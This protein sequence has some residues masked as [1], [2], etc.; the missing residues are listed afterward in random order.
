VKALKEW[1]DMQEMVD[2]G[3]LKRSTLEKALVKV[4][5]YES[6]EITLPQ[7]SQLMDIIQSAVDDASLSYEEEDEEDEVEQRGAKGF[8]ASKKVLS[9]EGAEGEEQEEGGWDGDE[10]GAPLEISEEEAAQEIF[11]ELKKPGQ[12]TL[13]LVDFLKW[14]DVQELVESGAL[15]RDNLAAAIENAGVSVEKGDMN[16]ETVSNYDLP[17]MSGV[18]F[19]V[20]AELLKSPRMF[21]IFLSFL[22]VYIFALFSQFYDLLQVIDNYVDRSKIPID[23]EGGDD[24]VFEKRITVDEDT[25]VNKVMSLVDGLLEDADPVLDDEE[26]ELAR[27]GSGSGNGSGVKGQGQGPKL[28]ISYVKGDQR[29][30]GEAALEA[31]QD[32]LDEQREQD[33]EEDEE[34]L[35]MVS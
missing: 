6:G 32:H 21:L 13:Q 4:G 22:S 33:E 7:F 15:S 11:E 5:S 16:F 27:Q 35:E 31:M 3:A 29:S 34:V 30:E 25:D 1:E 28:K 9:L 18:L 26:E 8:G 14:E 20:D 17:S 2:S 12:S 23:M 19:T 24:V 10:E